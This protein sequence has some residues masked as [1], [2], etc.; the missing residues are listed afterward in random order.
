MLLI[1]ILYFKKYITNSIKILYYK[2]TNSDLME[3][4]KWISIKM[5]KPLKSVCSSHA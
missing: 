4:I 3:W 2:L 1:I 5:S